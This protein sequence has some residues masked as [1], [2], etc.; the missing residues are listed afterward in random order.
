MGEQRRQHTD[1]N[2]A[3]KVGLL[4]RRQ[5]DGLIV[6]GK[7]F[8]G[9]ASMGLGH[10]PHLIDFCLARRHGLQGVVQELEGALIIPAFQ[11]RFG[12]V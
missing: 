8:I 5:P 3:K 6:I 10:G 7:R 2:S 11:S 9:T 1:R 12:V 4:A